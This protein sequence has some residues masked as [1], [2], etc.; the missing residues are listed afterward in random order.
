[1]I[2]VATGIFCD[3]VQDQTPTGALPNYISSQNYGYTLVKQK[4]VKLATYMAKL[5]FNVPIPEWIISVEEINLNEGTFCSSLPPN[6][7]MSCL[8]F[9]KVFKLGR[10]IK[11]SSYDRLLKSVHQ[12]HY[13]LEDATSQSQDH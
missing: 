9:A 1:M 7:F 5:M 6:Q 8:S 12:V 13:R 10:E 11:L 4:K 3:L 2:G